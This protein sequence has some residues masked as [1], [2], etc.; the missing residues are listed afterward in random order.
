MG[1]TVHTRSS[2]VLV[3]VAG[4]PAQ[5]V[6]TPTNPVTTFPTSVP[7]RRLFGE[8]GIGGQMLTTNHVRVLAHGE[9]D[10]G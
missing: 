9:P 5:A 8:W 1:P 2:F 6:A 7:A 10:G 4:S 3:T